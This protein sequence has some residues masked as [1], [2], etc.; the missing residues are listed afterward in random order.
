VVGPDCI[1]RKFG[2]FRAAKD[3]MRRH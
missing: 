2:L 3:G 1:G